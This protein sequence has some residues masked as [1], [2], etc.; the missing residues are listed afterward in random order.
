MSKMD[1]AITQR[2]ITEDVVGSIRAARGLDKDGVPN[3]RN[4]K[5][6]IV[7]SGGI[8]RHNQPV[9]LN[10]DW[11]PAVIQLTMAYGY[12]GSSSGYNAMNKDV[13]HY[14][15]RAIRKYADAIA[16][17]A[18]VLAQEDYVIKARDARIE[19]ESILQ[20]LDGDAGVPIEK[21]LVKE[22]E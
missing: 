2:R 1:E 17:H 22:G 21:L 19:A 4:D 7:F 15:L 5:H 18:I 12:Y 3:A 11:S 20:S 10:D 16:D 6:R 13:A 8:N 14:M 9:I